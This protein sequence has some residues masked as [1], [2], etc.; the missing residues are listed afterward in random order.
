MHRQVEYEFIHKYLKNHR[1]KEA[2][3]VQQQATAYRTAG[4]CI[5][6]NQQQDKCRDFKHN[7]FES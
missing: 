2:H 3:R 1:V 5:K 6:D 4:Y 7:Y